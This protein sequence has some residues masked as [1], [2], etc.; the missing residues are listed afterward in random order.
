MAQLNEEG[1]A[2]SAYQVDLRKEEAVRKAIR[3]IES[4]LGPT[5]VLV[6]NAAAL[7]PGPTMSVSAQQFSSDIDVSVTGALV[8]AQEV[9]SGMKARRAGT[10]L[11]TGGGLALRPEY[12][13]GVASLTAG[14]SALRGLSL[15]LSK[16]LAQDGIH[17]STVTI[18]G[19]VA[20]GTSLDPDLIATK[21]WGLYQETAPSWRS[22]IVLSG[23]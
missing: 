23:A 6:Y 8:C 5:D 17:V 16:E 15:L 7:S 14:K 4:D 21:Y 3:S 10:I 2:A 19:T 18:A 20:P 11:F 22:E 13:I 9:F 12:G 1:T